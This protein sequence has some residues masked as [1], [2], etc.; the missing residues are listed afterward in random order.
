[1]PS[2]YVCSLSQVATTVA[3]SGASHL[4]TL[5]HDGSRL[6]RPDSI[7]AERHLFLGVADIIIPLFGMV[8]PAEAHVRQ[9][10]EFVDAW[11]RTNPMVIHCFAGISRSTAGAFIA[12]CH[13]AP[14]QDEFAIAK[15]IR[16]ASAAASPN[17]RLVEVADDVLGRNG[18]MV[19]AIRAIG[20][21]VLAF[22]NRPFA[23]PIS[24]GA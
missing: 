18:R 15:R 2:I 6:V 22:E 1:M 16:A 21:G 19:D 3:T 20:G 13:V 14:E 11:D 4:V 10:T 23:L 17:T 9:L 12:L 8:R 5:L 7:P 24:E